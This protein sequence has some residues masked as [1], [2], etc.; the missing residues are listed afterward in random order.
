[1]NHT[2]VS[3]DSPIGFIGLGSMGEPMALNLVNA[4]A[5]IVV[6]NR[7]AAK[8][9]GLAVAGAVVAASAADVFARCRVV[10][11]MLADG[12]AMDDVLMRDRPAFGAFVRGRT[13]ISMATTAPA[14]SQG[15]ERDICTAGGRYVEAPVS[16]SRKP[17]ESGTLVAMVAG[18][19]ADVDAVR[20]LLAPLARSVIVCGAVPKALLMKLAVNQF[21]ITMTAGLAEAFHFARHQDLDTSQLVAVLDAGPMASEYSRMK[22]RKL[23]AGD[24]TVQAAVANVCES[25]RLICAAARGAAI[26]S[27]LIDVCD[28]LYTETRALGSANVDII[29]VIAAIEQRTALGVATYTGQCTGVF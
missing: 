19:P 5:D 14:Y 12:A 23:L 29:S 28:A 21:M 15:L 11:L 9:E 22:A 3:T 20:P 18:D 26:A 27:P 1:M 10:I 25:T 17:A 2:R 13:I 8:C 16:G 24:F 7:T 6:W 4:G